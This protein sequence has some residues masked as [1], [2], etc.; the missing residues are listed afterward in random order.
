MVLLFS[1]ILLLIAA[2]PASNSMNIDLSFNI[3]LITGHQNLLINL[4]MSF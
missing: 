1:S 3:V 4:I 2:A